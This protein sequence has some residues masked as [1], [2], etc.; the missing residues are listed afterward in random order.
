MTKNRRKRLSVKLEMRSPGDTNL[1]D[2]CTVRDH[3][4]FCE[5]D[6]PAWEVQQIYN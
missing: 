1:S 4:E 2:A 6:K 3:T 5:N